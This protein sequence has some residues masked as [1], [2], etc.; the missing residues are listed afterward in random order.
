MSET[1]RRNY[2]GLGPGGF[3][4]IDPLDNV[5]NMPKKAKEHLKEKGITDLY[6][7]AEWIKKS[8][9]VNTANIP[10]VG[11]QRFKKWMYLLTDHPEIDFEYDRDAPE[12]KQEW[13]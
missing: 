11:K 3:G 1:N 7:L 2:R 5:K 12:L 4:A 9:E 6:D 10:Y 8:N 13:R